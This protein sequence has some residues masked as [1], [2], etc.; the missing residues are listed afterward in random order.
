MMTCFSETILGNEKQIQ[1]IFFLVS[2]KMNALDIHRDF[3]VLSSFFV[4]VS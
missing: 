2:N 4:S 1:L 3:T